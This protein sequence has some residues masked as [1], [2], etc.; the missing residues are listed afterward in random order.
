MSPPCS[1]FRAQFSF[2]D[3]IESARVATGELASQERRLNTQQRKIELPKLEAIVKR[4][5]DW[6]RLM[7]IPEKLVKPEIPINPMNLAKLRDNFQC[8]ECEAF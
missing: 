6:K 7:P 1:D 4:A 2:P 3:L 5:G 8:M